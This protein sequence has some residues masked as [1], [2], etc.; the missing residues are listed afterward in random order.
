MMKV[1]RAGLGGLALLAGMI[2][3][4]A[5]PA[6][7]NH[8]WVYAPP[9]GVFTQPTAAARAVPVRARLAPVYRRQLVHYDSRQAPGTIIVDTRNNFLYLQL[10]GGKSLRY[11]V[12]TARPGFGW[13]GTYRISLKREWPDWTPPAAMLKRQPGIPRD[14][15]GGIDNPLGARALYIGQTLYR[16]HGTNQPW[17]IGK[18]ISSGC[19]RMLNADV[20]DLYG[21]VKIGA[22]VIVL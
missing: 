14:M 10:E 16:I 13:H 3:A 17:T 8:P 6:A 1:F 19:I 9:G 18:H 20:I 2:L 12:G 22:K 15:E 7:Q 5:A 21:R 11:G 4:G